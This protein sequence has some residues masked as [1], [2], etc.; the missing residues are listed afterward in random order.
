MDSPDEPQLSRSLRQL[1][2]KRNTTQAR[3]ID[4]LIAEQL[5]HFGIDRSTPFGESITRI[6]RG[7]YASQAGIEEL[8]KVTLESM[9]TLDT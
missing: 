8:W 5:T 9:A 7:L 2:P 1:S 4:D 6:V 3:S